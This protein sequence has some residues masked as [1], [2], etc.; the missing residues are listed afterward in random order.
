MEFSEGMTLTCLP[1][2]V[3]FSEVKDLLDLGVLEQ[4]E[5]T[6]V[7]QLPATIEFTE[8]Q[9]L[10]VVGEAVPLQDA[11]ERLRDGF[12][13]TAE[14]L[15]ELVLEYGGQNNL[16][17]LDDVRSVLRD[18]FSVTQDDVT[19]Q[20]D[21][22]DVASLDDV[23]GYVNTAR[24]LLFLFGVALVVVA[25]AIGFLR[26]RGWWGRLGWRALGHRGCADGQR[27]WCWR[28]PRPD[29]LRLPHPGLRGLFR[30]CR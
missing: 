16:D 9:L 8:Q 5:S 22:D 10:D 26:G 24:S 2:G 18:G 12:S 17:L 3:S 20:F 25:A 4:L 1:P 29:L 6:L 11:R 7:D 23:R 13:F 21:A 15:R 27:F 19:E 30:F 14:N 28:P